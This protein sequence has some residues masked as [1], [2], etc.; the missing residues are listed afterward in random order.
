M[1]ANQTRTL[2]AGLLS[3]QPADALA[4]YFALEHDSRRTRLFVRNDARGRATAF[5]A[6]CQTGIDLFAPLPGAI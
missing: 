5:V 3:T 2:V 1:V 6:V 4:S